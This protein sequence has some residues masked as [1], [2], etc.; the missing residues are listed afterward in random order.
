MHF[1]SSEP[2]GAR[3]SG[4]PQFHRS[5]PG[6]FPSGAQEIPLAAGLSGP[7][8]ESVNRMRRID[9]IAV[10]AD[11]L[12]KTAPL[13]KSSAVVVMFE[14]ER[15]EWAVSERLPAVPMR[16]V[17]I[18]HDGGF[19]TAVFEAEAAQ[20]LGPQLVGPS[21]LPNLDPYHVAGSR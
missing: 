19:D 18:G 2:H 21:P 16:R 9:R 15:A 7:F 1:S 6:H 12:Q 4:Q 20:R 5:P 3:E 8:L 13:F 11:V 14:A 17:V 10:D